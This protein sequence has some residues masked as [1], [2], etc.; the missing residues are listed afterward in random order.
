MYRYQRL[1]VP[2]SLAE[3][4]ES[5][6]RYAELISRLA[7]SNKVTF[8]H[9]TE[10]RDNIP[11]ELRATFPDIDLSSDELVKKRMQELV[12][13]NFPADGKREI[14]YE[15][16][17]GSPLIELLRRTKDSDIDLII[18]VKRKEPAEVG[19][20]PEKLIRKAPCSVLLV[21][22]E[23]QPAFSNILAPTDFSEGS[24]DAMDVAVAFASAG[25]IDEIHSLHAYTVPI[26]YYKTGKSHEEFAEIMK[27]HAEKNFNDFVHKE[28][29]QTGSVCQI[30]DLKGI[31]VTPI[32]MLEKK[33]AKAIE[34][35][36]KNHDIDLLVIGARGRRAGAGVFLGSVTEH[37]INTTTIPILAVKKK[38][39]GMSILD[40]IL[41]L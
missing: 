14:A 6:I 11:D 15:R 18:M 17:E 1:L 36:I 13:R 3:Q 21:P 20:L 28:V 4:D 8:A 30:K 32:L 7:N 29:C 12:T 26:G 34:E 25:G 31:E 41:K 35:V 40:A 27:G 33:P 38:G 19:S 9:V 24:I 39:T 23:T 5:A 10:P 2:L 16:L 22:E 37:Q